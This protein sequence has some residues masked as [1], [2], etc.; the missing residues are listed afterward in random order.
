MSVKSQVTSEGV[1]IVERK[2]VGAPPRLLWKAWKEDW[3]LQGWW[4]QEVQMT[5]KTG[6]KLKLGWPEGGFELRGR[7]V[8]I[9]NEKLLAFT[10]NW[11]HDKDAYP[12]LTTIRFVDEDNGLSTTLRIEQ[13]AFDEAADAEEIRSLQDGWSHY[14]GKLE[15]YLGQMTLV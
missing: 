15:N 3:H 4:P 9:L 6:G 1:L 11:A 12:F 7:F 8:D 5:F 10:W 14:L 2:F 13:R